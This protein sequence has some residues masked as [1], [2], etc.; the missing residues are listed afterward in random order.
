MSDVP[1]KVSEQ[2]ERTRASP[3]KAAPASSSVEAKLNDEKPER[4]RSTRPYDCNICF[5]DATEP[6]LTRCGHL[7]RVLLA[8]APAQHPPFSIAG[9]AC[10]L[11]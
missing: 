3:E 8:C 11:G 10:T 1:R 2:S 4:R 5:D 7:V 6:V 9:G